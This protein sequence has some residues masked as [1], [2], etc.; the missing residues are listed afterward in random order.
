MRL[1][2]PAKNK[3]LITYKL[4]SD[5]LFLLLIFFALAMVAD[6]LIAGIVSTHISFLKIIFLITL[7]LFALYVISQ[8]ADIEITT[9]LPNKKTTI[10]L[11]ILAAIL[12]FNSLFKLNLYLAT[13]FLGVALICGF[14][15]YKLFF[16]K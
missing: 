4:L 10:F 13:F 9:S 5:L 11:V 6:G 12:I 3:L 1:P 14:F 2:L 16:E 15:L 7:D 8:V